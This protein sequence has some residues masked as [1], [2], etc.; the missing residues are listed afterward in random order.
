MITSGEL[1]AGHARTLV[2]IEDDGKKVLL[3]KR[4]VEEGLSVREIERLA[5]TG[6]KRGTPA[7]R[8]KTKGQDALGVEEELKQILGTRV[9]LAMRGEKGKIEIEYYSRDELERLIELLKSLG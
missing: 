3:A 4:A 1:S 6:K 8:K 9:N 5:E 7:R 2:S